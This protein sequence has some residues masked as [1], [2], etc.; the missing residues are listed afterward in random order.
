MARRPKGCKALRANSQEGVGLVSSILDQKLSTVLPLTQ[1]T[2][3]SFFIP[4]SYAFPISVLEIMISSLT[5]WS[6]LFISCNSDSVLGIGI[7]K[8]T[9]PCL[10]EVQV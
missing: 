4:P 9:C 10:W 2:T 7:G 5:T 3:R 6:C 1:E 8:Q